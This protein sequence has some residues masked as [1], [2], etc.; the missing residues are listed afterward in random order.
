M[1]VASFMGLTQLF[2][3]KDKSYAINSEIIDKV[4]IAAN[5]LDA[6]IKKITANTNS[7]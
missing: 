3:K 6:V 1:S 7:Q 5:K 2:N 4:E